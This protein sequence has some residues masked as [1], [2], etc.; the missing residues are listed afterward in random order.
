M[1]STTAG[2]GLYFFAV[3]RDLG[4]DAL[5]GVGGIDATPLQVVEHGALQAVVCQVELAEFGEAAL[6]RNLED[7]G[8]LERVARAHNDVVFAVAAAGT[9][10]P[11]RLVTICADEE[12]VR[13]RMEA[14]HDVLGAALDRVEGRREWSVKVYVPAPTTQAATGPVRKAAGESGADY[15]RRK[16]AAA[17]QR[18]SAGEQS[19]QA[20]ERIHDELAAASD[21]SRTLPPQDPRLTGRQ[22]SMILNGA[23]L[24]P[25]D[26]GPAFGELVARVQERNPGT[27]VVAEGPWPPYSFATLEQP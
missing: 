22:D 18:H 14:L 13:A 8:W 5:T 27:T 25:I 10:A 16:R 15:L 17:E 23:Y 21:A 11:M 2:E 26:A 1:T 4:P 6:A 12:S 9:V 20:A 3:T 19:V 7:M 24:V